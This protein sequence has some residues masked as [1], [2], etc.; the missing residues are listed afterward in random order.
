MAGGGVMELEKIGK[1]WLMLGEAEGMLKENITLSLLDDSITEAGR[2]A[3]RGLR[4]YALQLNRLR[5]QYIP[6]F[7]LVD[8]CLPD[9]WED[10]G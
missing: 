9:G 8:D 1:A 3:L 6:A 10:E 2:E 5:Y 7:R 4:D